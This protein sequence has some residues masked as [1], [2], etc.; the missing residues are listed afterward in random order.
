M[1]NEETSIDMPSYYHS[2][3]QSNL[4]A[5]FRVK[6][7]NQYRALTQPTLLLGTWENE[8]DLA[9][10]PKRPITNWQIDEIKIKEIPLMIIEIVSPR[11]GTQDITEKI[12]KYFEQGVKSCWL[13]NPLTE[14]V[15]IYSPDWKKET[16][17][18]IGEKIYDPHLNIS[19]DFD[20]VFS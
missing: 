5:E 4:A 16:Y 10:F 9:I 7:R 6:Y 1:N 14:T 12:A 2:V 11:Q 15:H 19:I 20:E 3:V 17:F 13:I 8:P 18:K